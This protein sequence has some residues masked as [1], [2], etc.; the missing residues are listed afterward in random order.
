MAKLKKVRMKNNQSDMYLHSVQD[1]YYG[2]HPS[3]NGGLARLEWVLREEFDYVIDVMFRDG[4]EREVIVEYNK[5]TSYLARSGKDCFMYI[6]GHKKMA[7]GRNSAW[8]N[9]KDLDKYR[10]E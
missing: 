2:L 4:K 10:I 8:I 3:P 5:H 6:R 9:H 7:N 1:G